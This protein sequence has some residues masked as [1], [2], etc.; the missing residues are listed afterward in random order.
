MNRLLPF[1]LILAPV[2]FTGC[3]AP[4]RGVVTSVNQSSVQTPEKSYV[5]LAPAGEA[6]TLEM[7]SYQELVR[8]ELAR[9]GFREAPADSPLALRIGVRYKVNEVPVRV[10]LTR[11]THASA[12]SRGNFDDMFG[13]RSWGFAS[14]KDTAS[15]PFLSRPETTVLNKSGANREFEVAIL[16]SDGEQ[17]FSATARK[18][19]DDTAT[20]TVLP[21]LVHSALAEFAR[22]N[23]SEGQF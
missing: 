6:D 8:N 4:N 5:L 2:L 7:R 3:A 23:A 15:A 1:V 11:R 12:S 13:P 19:S 21:A 9:M 14:A 17:L 20:P 18:L 10:V 16:G 22:K